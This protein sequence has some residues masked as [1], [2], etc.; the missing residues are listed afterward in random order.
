MTIHQAIEILEHYNKWRKE[1]DVEQP[2]PV[3]IGF[4]ID[5]VTCKMKDFISNNEK[6]QIIDLESPFAYP[7]DKI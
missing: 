6:P 1:A 3:F 4:A 5:L 7:D 2:S